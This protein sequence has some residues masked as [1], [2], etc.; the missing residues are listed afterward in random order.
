MKFFVGIVPPEDIYNEV[1]GIQRKFGDNRLEP[2]I[3]LRPPVT[4]AEEVAWT[5]AIQQVCG[6][7]YPFVIE[8]PST[9]Y[10]G[11]R[12]LFIN[13][14]S[15]KLHD[16]H[17][18]L[19]EAIKPYEKPEVNKHKDQKYH[20]HLTL[21]RS[22]CGFTME[23]FKEMKEITDEFLTQRTIFFTVNSVRIYHKPLVTGRYAPKRD[24]ALF[25]SH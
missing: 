7:F 10:F 13:T 8:L 21:G 2:H 12:V 19:S 18:S 22:W 6:S 11:K 16:L 25:N 24:I 20:P 1:A 5:K 14:I 9:D 23:G 15:N 3:T 4:V 17:H